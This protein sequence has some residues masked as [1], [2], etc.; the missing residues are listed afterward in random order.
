MWRE[1]LLWTVAGALAGA[2]LARLMALA[3]GLPDRTLFYLSL[4]LVYVLF[5]AYQATLE[6]MDES[7]RHVEDLDRT[8]RE[9]YASFQ[10]VGEALAAPLEAGALYRLIVDLCH[11]MLAPQMSGLCLYREGSLHLMAARFA[12][13]FQSGHN[14]SIADAVQKAAATALRQ[15]QPTS[16]PTKRMRPAIRAPSL[17]PFPCNRRTWSTA[18]SA[19][20]T[21]P[22]AGSRTLG[23]SF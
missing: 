16:T 19:C 9:L 1:G 7:R 18:P 14:G 21:I 11:E 17:S 8:A 6:R 3:Y 22:R 4:P 20:S 15:G 10:R 5:A 12:S 13:S 23:A 2:S